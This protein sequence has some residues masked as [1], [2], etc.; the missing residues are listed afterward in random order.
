MFMNSNRF[1][2]GRLIVFILCW[3]SVGS[4]KVNGQMFYQCMA[5]PAGTYQD[6]N[7]CKV[8]PKG[9]FCVGGI[10]EECK[11]GSYSDKD[12]LSS[13]IKCPDYTWNNG[14]TS[15][16][17]QIYLKFKAMK[18]DCENEYITF[19]DIEKEKRFWFDPSWWGRWGLGVDP[20]GPKP[21]KFFVG[22]N[23]KGEESV[24]DFRQCRTLPCTIYGAY[25]RHIDIDENLNYKF[26]LPD[27]ELY[28]EASDWV[29]LGKP[30]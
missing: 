21:C 22:N 6:G 4:Y 15:K 23:G 3:I 17:E 26:Y 25:G 9:H 11:R 29:R 14:G 16:C 24:V 19:L 20:V 30:K 7:E 13:C 28:F 10:K 5:C 8:C 2:R 1:I 18:D 12:G 27:G